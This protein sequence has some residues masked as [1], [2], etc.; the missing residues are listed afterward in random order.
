MAFELRLEAKPVDSDAID[1]RM[2]ELGMEQ[3]PDKEC[4]GVTCKQTL[5]LPMGKKRETGVQRAGGTRGTKP[6]QDEE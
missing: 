4:G 3:F 5:I 1:E 6:G 2:V